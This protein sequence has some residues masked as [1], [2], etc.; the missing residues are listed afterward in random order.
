[1]SFALCVLEKNGQQIPAVK[2]G[3]QFYPLSD[4]APGLIANPAEGLLDLLPRW[5]ESFAKL[6]QAVAGFD[7]AGKATVGY[8]K[9]PKKH[10]FKK[11]QSGNPAGRPPNVARDRKHEAALLAANWRV[12][13]VWECDIKSSLENMADELAS[14]LKTEQSTIMGSDAKK[15]SA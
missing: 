3:D 7:G 1:M 14:W 15:K 2:T 9:P 8:G 11:G 6:E 12:A 13:I 4:V 5:D 10:R